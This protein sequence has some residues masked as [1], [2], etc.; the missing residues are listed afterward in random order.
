VDLRDQLQ[1]S[2]GHAYTLDRELGG[3]GMSR[4]F[5]ATETAL[6]RQVVV[7][8]LPAE[9]AGGVSADRFNREI[10]LAARLQH[11]NI[12]PL[13]SAG[14]SAGVPYY[15]MPLVEGESLRATLQRAGELPVKQA[16]AILRDVARA[17]DYAHAHGVAHRD[18]KPDNV[19]LSG[20][21]AVVTDFGVAKA[22]MAAR[23]GTETL[24]GLGVAIGTPAYM[25][26]E[27]AAGDTS[28]HRSDLYAFGCMAYEMLT[29]GPPFRESSAPALFAA[30]ATRTPVPLSDV[31]PAVPAPLAQLVSR[32]L[33]KRPADRPQSAREIID[34]LDAVSTPVAGSATYVAHRAATAPSRRAAAA[35]TGGVLLAL[36]AIVWVMMRPAGPS[37]SANVV[38]VTPFRVAGADASLR[39]LRE[40]MLD[41]ISAK[42]SGTTH[43]IDPRTVLNGWRRRGGSETTDLTRE[44]SLGLAT[45]LGAGRLLEGEI[46]GTPDR[47]VISA[48]LVAAPGGAA[49][50]TARVV[51]TQQALPVLVDSLMAMLLVR[52]AGESDV[53]ARSL[54]GIPFDAIQA[55]LAGQSAYRRGHYEAALDQFNRAL[56]VDSSFA[57]AGIHAWLADTWVVSG[58]GARGYRLALQQSDRLGPRERLLLNGADART[59]AGRVRSNAEQLADA[60]R[61]ASASPDVPEAWYFLGDELMHYGWVTTNGDDPWRRAIVAL[62]R[63]LALD[64]SFAPAREHLPLLYAHVGDTTRAMAML[65]GMSADSADNADMNRFWLGL[66]PDSI[67]RRRFV[68]R[69]IEHRDANARYFPVASVFVGQY[70]ADGEYALTRL[71]AKAA[72]DAERTQLAS[73]EWAV[74]LNQ[75]QPRRAAVTARASRMPA[76]SVLL[77]TAFWDGDSSDARAARDTARR[78]YETPAAARD[79]RWVD[80]VFALAQE[81]LAR[82]DT[83]H[84][85]RA[86]ALLRAYAPP[87]GQPWLADRPR[88]LALILEAQHAAL[89]LRTD[90]AAVLAAADSAVRLGIAGGV[91]SVGALVVARL[92]EQGGDSRGAYDA[93]RRIAITTS[94]LGPAFYSTYRLERARIAAA[95]GER[96]DA[97]REYRA[98]LN[99]RANA[100]PEL[101][102]QVADVRKELA[103]LE[104]LA[105]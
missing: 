76:S 23:S 31:R 9:L 93:I 67:T 5:V 79:A 10:Q 103:R 90:R 52:E 99:I 35:I 97:M 44:Q 43:A 25:S 12:V 41:L 98:W 17:L 38:A 102:P 71:K 61:A 46:V 72:T 84:A 100:E 95:I 69:Q 55:Y 101:Q 15:T 56:D 13:L 30:H 64:S 68:D 60:E 42:L 8:V 40:G 70:M 47:L 66:M 104:K 1:T 2:L 80:L 27:Q 19:L 82:R 16:V 62:E 74:A 85:A 94:P 22:L 6:R 87:A 3:G 11:P 91:T 50:A 89:A 49:R 54:A 26:P 36:A 105:Q 7:K 34:A 78:A 57:L 88:A 96:A 21:Y 92:K 48:T 53:Q 81:E 29:G 65:G 4:V 18:I 83:T 63:A 58:R 37:V 28:D 20:D 45:S 14:E 73:M 39:N 51:G 75:G 24:T 32:C 59:L 77:A 86:V 33:E